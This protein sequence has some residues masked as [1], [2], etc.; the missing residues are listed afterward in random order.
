MIPVGPVT[1]FAG[2]GPS[3]LEAL[4]I[5]EARRTLCRSR[6]SEGCTGT[7]SGECSD[8]RRVRRREHPDL[9]VAAPEAR[10]RSN[11]PP[12]EESPG[13]RETTIPASLVRAIAQ[14]APGRPYE[15]ATR[16]LVLLDVDRTDAAAFSALLKV[17]EEPPPHARFLLTATRPRLLP[18][19]I[20][21]RVALRRVP[22]L[23]AAEI[24]RLLTLSGMREEEAEA[25]AAFA[26]DGVEE[27]RAID[28]PAARLIR[29]EMLNAAS[30]VLLNGSTAWSVVLAAS[31]T[32]EDAEATESRLILFAALLR[33]AAAAAADPSG[34]HV[35]HRERYQDLA[36]L[37]ESAGAKLL[38]AASA[39]LALAGDLASSRR[40]PRLSVEAFALSLAPAPRGP[41]TS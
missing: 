3:R 24:A 33:D 18:D 34:A 32:A 21:S 23:A 13:S 14:D 40:G 8:C 7:E 36:R 4:A 41:W 16:V 27:A 5:D 19:T 20:L 6:E 31:L 17:L 29:D 30:G 26:P 15:S 35:L 12:F 2:P 39:A 38:S 1:L 28:L 10:R 37:G 22:R 11:V 9:L 25:R